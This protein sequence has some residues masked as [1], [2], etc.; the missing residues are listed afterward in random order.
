MSAIAE[1][2][3]ASASVELEEAMRQVKRYLASNNPS[4]RLIQQKMRKVTEREE[5]LKRFH[6]S[7]CNK[8]D[9]AVD[10]EEAMKFIRE[11]SDAATDC[12]DECM[13]Y[14]EEN[15]INQAEKEKYRTDAAE[16]KE[17]EEKK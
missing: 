9:V 15:E 6:F 5:E 13:I 8:A 11:K 14:I 1:K 12:V 17:R 4:V 10:S 16:F 2:L 7:Y 3:R